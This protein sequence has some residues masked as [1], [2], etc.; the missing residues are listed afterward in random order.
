MQRCAA[1]RSALIAATVA[2]AASRSVRKPSVL[3]LAGRSASAATWA[4]TGHGRCCLAYETSWSIT[5]SQ[6][7][8]SSLATGPARIAAWRRF[9]R[10]LK[11]R[12]CCSSTGRSSTAATASKSLSTSSSSGSWAAARTSGLHCA[13]TAAKDLAAGFGFA[14]APSDCEPWPSRPVL[15]VLGGRE[16]PPRWRFMGDGWSTSAGRSH[17]AGP[18]WPA[19]CPLLPAEPAEPLPVPGP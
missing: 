4:L 9:L 13:T 12:R 1:T 7:I 10:C 14:V 19:C 3:S 6:A 16:A 8:A 17:A 15:G 11:R 18:P 5:L 2:L